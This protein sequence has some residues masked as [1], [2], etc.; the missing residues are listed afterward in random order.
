M[1]RFEERVNFGIHVTIYYLMNAKVGKLYNT[2]R[3]NKLWQLREY[4][5]CKIWVV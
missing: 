3:K 4:W 2:I 1:I 5:N